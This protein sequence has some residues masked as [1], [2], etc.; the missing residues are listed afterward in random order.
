LVEH[1][2]SEHLADP[3]RFDTVVRVARRHLRQAGLLDT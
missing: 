1:E 2:I 3:P